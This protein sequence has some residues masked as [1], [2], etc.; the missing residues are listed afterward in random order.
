MTM[1]P[2]FELIGRGVAEFGFCS[3]PANPRQAL[4]GLRL[5]IDFLPDPVAALGHDRR[6]AHCFTTAQTHVHAA[7]RSVP[8]KVHDALP[9]PPCCPK[10]GV[11]G[12]YN[13]A[14]TE[15]PDPHLVPRLR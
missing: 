3:I 6:E 12:R 15:S 4:G 5:L 8:D 11:G 7:A 13:H 9:V 2:Y 10:A 14:Y 1:M